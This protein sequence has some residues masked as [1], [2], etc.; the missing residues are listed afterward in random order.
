MIDTF[1]YFLLCIKFAQNILLY[2]IFLFHKQSHWFNLLQ[3]LSYLSQSW[4]QKTLYRYIQKYLNLKAKL[5]AAI[6][7]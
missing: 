5:D 3:V 4:K 1:I 7:Q 6:R 2:L